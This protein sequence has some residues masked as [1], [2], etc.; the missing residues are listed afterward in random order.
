VS[1]VLAS[2]GW[3]EWL[4]AGALS[5]A[6]GWLFL[7]NL[8]DQRLWQD[9]AQTALIAKTVLADGVPRGYDGKNYFSQERGREYGR[10]YVYRWHPWFPFYLLAGVFG[11][12]GI[13]EWTS[14]LPFALMGWATVPLCYVF[15]RSLWQSRRAAVLAAVLVATCVPF[16]VLSRQCRYYSPCA[17]FSLLGLIAYY[18]LV[19]RRHWAAAVFVVSATLLFHS[20][21]L[22]WAVLVVVVL[23]HAM[24]FHRDRLAATAL[25][26]GVTLLLNL[27]WL[28]WLLSPPTVGRYPERMDR[29]YTP[30]AV[31]AKYVI[32]T[33]QYVFS[34]VL[35]LLVMLMAGVSKTRA[36]RFI[37]MDPTT[38][39]SGSLIVL[40]IAVTYISLC[41]VT[42]LH[43]F[44]YLAPAIP[45]LCLLAA[46]ILDSAMRLHWSLGIVGL[47]VIFGTGRL[48]DYLYEIT[49]HF[50]GPVDGLV[51]YLNEH[52]KP[53]DVVAITYDDM[54]LKLYTKM[55]IVGGLTGEDLTP[56]L[57]ADWVIFRYDTHCDKDEAVKAFLAKNLPWRQYRKIV[58]DYPDTPSHNREDPEG[59]Y[60][61][62]V[63][64][65]P[66]LVIFQKKA[67]K[68]AF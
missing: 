62:T 66:R 21:F 18:H 7:A 27:P 23:I 28:I 16:L 32:Q 5:I 68:E 43:F 8:G 53:D 51:S 24:I 10:N 4:W 3:K 26:S 39:N 40:F 36:K 13:N 49:H 60:Y 48:P 47:A 15:A 57:T 6:A 14:R 19:R 11:L 34:P 55:R 2:F 42:P 12:C 38:I 29:W 45:L 63:T 20:L 25:W 33:F 50:V 31:A 58:L 59:H 17:L 54:P 35:A 1:F 44:R 56:T 64:D 30:L 37:D 61:R 22:Y 41:V 67:E 46:K 65:A 52:G 9:E